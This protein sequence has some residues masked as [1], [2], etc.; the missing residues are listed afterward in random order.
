[1]TPDRHC[2]ASGCP[3]SEGN[4]RRRVLTPPVSAPAANGTFASLGPQ[5]VKGQPPSVIGCY[6]G[7]VRRAWR[8]EQV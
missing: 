1:M 6:H 4:Q 3:R 5:M 7:A 8:L 2:M